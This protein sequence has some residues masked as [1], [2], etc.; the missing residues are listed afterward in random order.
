[1]SGDPVTGTGWLDGLLV[2]PGDR[3]MCLTTGPINFANGD[4]QEIVDVNLAGQSTDR[5]SSISLMKFYSD[6]DQSAYND[7]FKLPPAPPAPVVTVTAGNN[8][9]LLNWTSD[10]LNAA[11]ENQD[12]LGFKFEGYNVYQYPANST[13]NGQLIATFDKV[14]LITKIFDDVFD[15]ITGAVVYEP[16]QFGGD[17]GIAHYID[18]KS[19][20]FQKFGANFVNGQT[21]Y[22]AVTAYSYNPTPGLVGNNLESPPQII[23]VTPH[24]PALGVRNSSKVGQSVTATHSAGLADGS[25][26]VNIVDPSRVTGD[27]Y[28]VT[29]SETDSVFNASAGVNFANPRWTLTDVTKNKAVISR[30]TVYEAA[31]SKADPVVDGMQVAINGAPFWVPGF[32]IGSISY[33]PSADSNLAA[34]N[35]GDFA[36]MGG[37]LGVAD[38]FGFGSELNP[39]NIT[40]SVQIKFVAQGSG[41]NAYDFIRTTGSGGSLYSGFFPQPFTVWDISNPAS[42]KQIDFAFMELSGD[43]FQNNIWAPGFTAGDREYMFIIDTAYTATAKAAYTGN[44]LSG[45][46]PLMPVA[47]EG[48]FVLNDTTK[49]AYKPGDVWTIN[50]VHLVTPADQWTFSTGGLQPKFSASLE[51]TDVGEINV[52]PNPYFGFN[53]AEVNRYNRFVTFN[54]LP[55]RA[56]IKIYNLSGL[57][58]RTITKNDPTQF[59]QWDLSN[60]SGLPA[61]AGVYVAYIDLPDLGKTKELKLAIIPETQYL[62]RP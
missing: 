32:E 53:A 25:L 24:G 26:L 4:T 31:I 38:A 19:D 1:L 37:G 13:A 17:F 30:S 11:D 34:A 14:D 16:V 59:A 9:I 41:Q 33:T 47:Y 56:T 43:R 10:S 36:F 42:P 61:A 39:W 62:D 15:P 3:R 46:L 28:K 57:L 44:H 7:L 52:F 8:E 6:L 48:W 58:V 20:A 50:A 40:M 22:F 23:P 2:G 18:L 45:L 12:T 29:V 55:T 27:S 51:A 49:P 21:Y 54:H 60:G 35:P 5:Y